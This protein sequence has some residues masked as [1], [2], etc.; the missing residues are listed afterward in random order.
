MIVF[1]R[2]TGDLLALAVLQIISLINYTV[3]DAQTFSFSL[4]GKRLLMPLM[5]RAAWQGLF[6]MIKP[7]W[8]RVPLII[9]EERRSPTPHD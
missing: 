1:L 2:V 6:G 9:L 3:K 5:D 7:T 4:F 8:Q